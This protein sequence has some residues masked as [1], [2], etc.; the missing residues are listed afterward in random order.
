M[1]FL[2]FMRKCTFVHISSI[3]DFEV[4]VGDRIAQL[5]LEKI[6]TPNVME[7]QD[8]D[9]TVRGVGGF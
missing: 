5:I 2:E 4:K 1:A 8:L 3:V 9:A 7:V 6:V